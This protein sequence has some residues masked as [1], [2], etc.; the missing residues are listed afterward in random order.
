MTRNTRAFAVGACVL[1]LVAAIGPPALGA[2]ERPDPSDVHDSI[3][4]ARDNLLESQDRRG[5]HW[6]G[7]VS[8]GRDGIVD[9]RL[10]I[11]YAL[12]LERLSVEDRRQQ[13]A[14][15]YVLSKRAP[16]GGWNDTAANY[17]GLLLLET[18]D[19]ERYAGEI[20][21]IE[22]EIQSENM[23]LLEPPSNASSGVSDIFRVKLFYALMSDRYLTEELFPRDGHVRVPQLLFATPAFEDGFDP[24]ASTANPYAVDWLLSTAILGEAIENG[25]V[26]SEASEAAEE[27]LLARRL[28]DGTWKGSLDN[29]L[30]V[31][32]LH[33]LGYSPDDPEVSRALEH[34]GADRLAPDGHL[35]A[36][37]LS[38][39]DTAWALSALT[40]SGMDPRD[41]ELERAAQWLVD[42]KRTDFRATP[43]E[44]ELTRP[45]VAFRPYATDGWGYRPHMYPDWDDTATAITALSPYGSTIVEDDVAFLTQVQNSDGSWS[46]FVTDFEPFSGTEARTV[47]RAIGPTAYRALFANHPAPGVTGHALEALGQQGR[48]VEND[49]AVRHAVD[50][51]E[52]HRAS[53]GLWM[54]VWG[55]GYTYGTSRVLVGTAEVGVDQSRPM[56]REATEALIAHQNSD[57]GWGERSAYRLANSSDDQ[58][59]LSAESTPEQTAW[60]VRGLLAAGVS[61]DHPAIRRGVT[62]LL[63]TQRSDGSWE[64]HRV[65]ANLGPPLYRSPV[66][67][68][69]SVLRALSAYA[70][71]AGIPIEDES[72]NPLDPWLEQP[73]LAFIAAVA[74]TLSGLVLWRWRGRSRRRSEH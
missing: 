64:S 61:P 45:P 66:V 24:N 33:E 39:W 55:E 23:S 20:S 8:V 7:N 35:L 51:L 43:L 12:M 56:I 42:V 3:T 72:S 27:V 2:P 30:A 71:A 22:N 69:A 40:A 4:S 47:E 11:Y 15:S 28:T 19:A 52:T 62:Y 26:D 68:Q 57:G 10:T 46:A 63:E 1:L 16:N 6:A 31:L 74:L 65:M 59:Y 70:S 36:Y 21:N 60:A 58:P 37:R 53:N 34:L 13:R 49:P 18:V 38:V 25:S 44:L 17:G 5:D 41:P 67:T 32:A 73:I 9:V 14:L 48:T 29:V 50:Y 54:G